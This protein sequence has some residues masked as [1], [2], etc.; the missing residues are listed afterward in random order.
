MAL[1]SLGHLFVAAAFAMVFAVAPSPTTNRV[2]TADLARALHRPA[3]FPVPA[4]VLRL[5][6]GE[7]AGLVL[8]SQRVEPK[9]AQRSGYRFV[10]PELEGALKHIFA[11]TGE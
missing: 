11:P 1:S 6:L 7:M 5:V 3:I 10:Y 4:F 8:G 2:F 9:V